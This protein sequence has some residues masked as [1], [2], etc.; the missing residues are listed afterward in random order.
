MKAGG[1][2]GNDG[3]SAFQASEAM[4]CDKYN[5]CV[6]ACIGAKNLRRT[7]LWYTYL[8]RTKPPPPFVKS[9]GYF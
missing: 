1:V 3:E 7:K 8:K 5:V 6:I 4:I 9:S 2:S